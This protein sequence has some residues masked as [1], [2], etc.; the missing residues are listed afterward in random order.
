MNRPFQRIGSISNAHVGKDFELIAQSFF[1]QQGLLL[2]A[3]H[4]IEIGIGAIKKG[5]FFDLGC[6]NQKVIAECKSHRWTTGE[7]IPSAKLTVW[8]EAMFYFHLAPSSYRKIM[9]VLHDFSQ[10]RN[11]TLA[12]YYLKIYGHM[13]PKGVEFW[14]YKESEQLAIKII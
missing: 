12:E 7:N 11:L 4:K 9:F 8:N 5:H 2:K 13:I 10:R 6:D 14:E 1:Q 3:N